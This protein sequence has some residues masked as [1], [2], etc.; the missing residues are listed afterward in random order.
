MGILQQLTC[1]SQSC[2]TPIQADLPRHPTGNRQMT[3]NSYSCGL[4]LLTVSFLDEENGELLP[5]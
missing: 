2:A 1:R 5:Q 3:R 4:S